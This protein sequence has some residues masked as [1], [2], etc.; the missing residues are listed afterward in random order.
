MA[1]GAPGPA[2][3]VRAGPG[4]RPR[5]TTGRCPYDSNRA[6]K[7]GCSAQ[8]NSPANPHQHAERGGYQR[9][10]EQPCLV[11]Q[12]GQ[13]EQR[14]RGRRWRIAFTEIRANEATLRQPDT[15]GVVTAFVLPPSLNCPFTGTQPRRRCLMRTIGIISLVASVVAVAVRPVPRKLK[16]QKRIGNTVCG[17]SRHRHAENRIAGRSRQSVV[18]TARIGAPF[19]RQG[20]TFRQN[21]GLT[22]LVSVDVIYVTMPSTEL[23]RA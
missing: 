23:L 18:A 22:K 7:S 19:E 2:G 16:C 20:M 10:P 8:P 21:P 12:R 15:R 13:G 6:R 3:R 5:A 14:D 4:A 11:R 17:A 9:Q 1:A